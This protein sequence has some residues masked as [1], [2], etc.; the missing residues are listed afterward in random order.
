M[1]QNLAAFL[2]WFYPRGDVVE[3]NLEEVLS[4][5][6]L[7][8]ARTPTWF[9]ED[10]AATRAPVFSYRALLKYV[11]ETL[12]ID[13]VSPPCNKHMTLFKRLC[14][15]DT[16]LSVNYD[17]IADE[18]LK[19]VEKDSDGKLPR[20]SRMAKMSALVGQANFMGGEPPA[21]LEVEREWGF[22]LKLHGSLDWLYCS[23]RQCPNNW[24][25]YCVGVESF[26]DQAA[27]QSCRLCG[28]PIQVFI[29]PPLLAKTLDATGR[30]AFLWNLAL[31]ELASATE[32]TIIGL[33]FVPS[34]IE[35]KW[36]VRQ[37]NALRKSPVSLEIVNP[38]AVDR[39]AGLALFGETRAIRLFSTLDDYLEGRS[40]TQS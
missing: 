19:S 28:W 8:E 9:G 24:R 27:G 29:V 7:S 40:L 17:V 2:Q 4:F 31:R 26:Q 15:Q 36:L 30:L 11:Q 38:N 16:V 23:N 18:A 34:D 35:L 20:P 12:H 39:E 13:P 10:I 14:P 32:V 25:F 33:S 6:Y 37:A 3:Y 5:I 21:L 1:P 22:Y